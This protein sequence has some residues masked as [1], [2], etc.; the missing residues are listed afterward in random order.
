MQHRF[1]AVFMFLHDIGRS[2]DLAQT[3][4]IIPASE[5]ARILSSR[6]TPASLSIPEPLHLDI[7]AIEFPDAKPF[8]QISL[9]AKIYEDGV[10]SMI[11]RVRTRIELTEIHTIRGLQ[12]PVGEGERTTIG[13]WSNDQ[14][15]MLLARILPSVEVGE[16]GSVADQQE[17][18]AAFCLIDTIRNPARFV[19]SHAQYLSTFLL[20][21]NPEIELHESQV[22]TTL[23]HRFSFKK[24]DM[25]ILDLDRCFII[26]PDR[27]YEDILLILELANYQ[28]LELR[29]L[30]R[31]LDRWL[32]LAED[33]IRRVYLKRSHRLR[34]LSRKL[35]SLLPLRLDAL[36]VLENLENT[37][38][39]I[40]D[41][42]LGQV[43]EHVCTLM[44]TGSWERSVH[45]RLEA[46][47]EIYSMAKVDVNERLLLIMEIL[48]VLL[49]GFELAALMFPVLLR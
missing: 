41:Y 18:Y 7:A 11:V 12:F 48:V 1:E 25:I 49:I 2:V 35:G 19:D 30:D 16:Y 4:R 21:E 43:Y 46:L 13:R 20:G 10:I 26:D 27:D 31:L 42:Y 34:S 9:S 8:E 36:F 33:D 39:I 15:Q 24:N 28:L 32:D 17:R 40:G 29:T 6:D 47:Q 23:D 3:R 45:R 38:K 44:G 22:R 37:A 5:D 14:F